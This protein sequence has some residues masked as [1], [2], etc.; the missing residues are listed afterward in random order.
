MSQ[1]T[2]ATIAVMQ[3][4]QRLIIQQQN[5]AKSA[6]GLKGTASS[7]R[8]MPAIV[9][10]QHMLTQQQQQQQLH[11]SQMQQQQMQQQQMQQQQMQHLQ[12][13]Q[14]QQQ[15]HQFQQQQFQMQHQHMQQQQNLQQQ[16][17]QQQQQQQGKQLKPPRNQNLRANASKQGT[18]TGTPNPSSPAPVPSPK[19]STV[20]SPGPTGGTSLLQQQI[21]SKAYASPSPVFQALQ[22]A[23]RPQPTTRGTPA[24]AGIHL[25]DVMPA[26]PTSPPL[27]L[28]GKLKR[29]L[30]ARGSSTSS[31]ALSPTP[32]LERV[33]EQ[34]ESEIGE[35]DDAS[36]SASLAAIARGPAAGVGAKRPAAAIGA[37]A[38]M[39][40]L[41]SK[42]FKRGGG[43][44]NATKLSTVTTGSNTPSPKPASKGL[45]AAATAR[46]GPPQS[47]TTVRAEWTRLP[48][49][50]RLRILGCLSPAQ[51]ARF[52]ACDAL[53]GSAVLWSPHL[54][55]RDAPL[56]HLL[57][58]TGTTRLAQVVEVLRG[59]AP[60]LVAE[61]NIA[62]WNKVVARGER[63]PEF[64]A[65]A[66]VEGCRVVSWLRR[67]WMWTKEL[68]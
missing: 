60:S 19:L 6:V 57:I 64:V 41:Q 9:P 30:S 35:D 24:E 45:P 67:L 26:P 63:C 27:P 34:E 61:E 16:Q 1:P 66:I 54:R 3:Q 40:A 49:S 56:H 17:K 52:R 31:L 7:P 42:A 37:G 59:Q 65:F 46:W 48:E 39:S 36:S 68:Q 47:L 15:F 58:D 62:F 38:G 4:Q 14:Q 2:A 8:P 28:S 10:G 44:G 12:H 53:A 11:M 18:P 22:G 29:K 32:E 25:A 21:M 23:W 43:G 13:M 5:L 55:V 50:V 51:L 20:H 33:E